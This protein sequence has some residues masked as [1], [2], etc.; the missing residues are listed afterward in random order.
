MGGI[1]HAFCYTVRRDAFNLQFIAP[2]VTVA[3]DAR[4]IILSGTLGLLV[5][6][7]KKVIRRSVAQVAGV[8]A[9]AVLV[10]RRQG[11]GGVS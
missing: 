1:E 11:A 2:S 10:S 6:D 4:G 3:V 5:I 8:T 9:V 7:S